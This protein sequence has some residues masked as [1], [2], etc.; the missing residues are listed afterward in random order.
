[1]EEII[2]SSSSSALPNWNFP[3]SVG[4]EGV[5]VVLSL[6]AL[7]LVAELVELELLVVANISA[8]NFS[9]CA[10]RCCL[11]PNIGC[12]E[13]V[14]EHPFTGC[15]YVKVGILARDLYRPA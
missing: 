11:R 8:I 1:M 13:R 4:V 7:P 10:L 9:S 5:E 12:E 6:F 3:R 2:A 14:I 15:K